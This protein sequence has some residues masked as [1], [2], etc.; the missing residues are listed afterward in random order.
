MKPPFSVD[1]SYFKGMSVYDFRVRLL[2]AFGY[3]SHFAFL[4]D[5]EEKVSNVKTPREDIWKK[6]N[7]LGFAKF[8]G[9]PVTVKNVDKLAFLT[10]EEVEDLL[11]LAEKCPELNT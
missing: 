10:Q 7:Q 4:G 9:D 5:E 6:L 3:D 1:I 8:E 11:V 2:K